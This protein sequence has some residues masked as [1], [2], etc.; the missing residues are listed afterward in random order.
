MANP[1]DIDNL[2]TEQQRVT[3]VGKWTNVNSVQVT[4][5]VITGD[6]INR[7]VLFGGLS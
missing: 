7:F 6:G 5:T 4:V 3:I 1:T 2:T